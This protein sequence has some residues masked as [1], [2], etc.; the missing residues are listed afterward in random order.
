MKMNRNKE[1]VLDS[2]LIDLE[3]EKAFH[4]YQGL[5]MLDFRTGSGKSYDLVKNIARFIYHWRKLKPLEVVDG[6]GK[7]HFIKQIVVLIP[8][9]I[10]FLEHSKL[11]QQLIK[12]SKNEY[13]KE[14]AL[15]IAKESMY[16]MPSNLDCMINGLSGEKG[17]DEE[18]VQRI[19]ND[20]DKLFDAKEAKELIQS[21]H[22][23][24]DYAKC[25]ADKNLKTYEA[26]MAQAAN[27]A[28]QNIRMKMHLFIQNCKRAERDKERSDKD[29]KDASGKKEK[30]IDLI[31]SFYE[32]AN[33][34][35]YRVIVTSVDKCMYSVDP[36]ISSRYSIYDKEFLKDKLIILDE[37]DS[38]YVRMKEKI[39]E[40]INN[41]T[42]P[43]KEYVKV[44][45]LN[46]LATK[47]T[48]VV[49]KAIEMAFKGKNCSYSW[50]NLKKQGQKILKTYY[51]LYPY[52]TDEDSTQKGKM[53]AL[54][55]DG[56]MYTLSE[57]QGYI[58]AIKSA[59]RSQ[60][61]LRTGKSPDDELEMK[62]EDEKVNISGFFRDGDRFIYCFARFLNEVT[63]KYQGIMKR[64]EKEKAKKNKGKEWNSHLDS[65]GERNI[66]FQD[67]L[68]SLLNMFDIRGKE[69]EFYISYCL[70]LR[71]KPKRINKFDIDLSFYAL[72]Y[73]IKIIRD[74]AINQA[75]NSVIYSYLGSRTPESILLHMA[76]CTHVICLSATALN[77]SVNENFDMSYLED[78]LQQ[79]FYTVSPETKLALRKFYAHK[80][81]PYDTEECTV[82]VVSLPCNDETI[83]GDEK[84]ENLKAE[85]A[86]PAF[87]HPEI[88]NEL[89]AEVSQMV[90]EYRTEKK[91]DDNCNYISGRYMN[92]IHG[93]YDFIKDPTL[94]SM[95]VL[96]KAALKENNPRFDFELITS[97]IQ[98]ICMDLGCTEKIHIVT[99]VSANFKA[100]EEEVKG[101]WEN[102]EKAVF[103]ST[104]QT[105][106][107][108]SN[109]QYKIPSKSD[110]KKNLVVLLP[111]YSKGYGLDDKY[112]NKDVD[113]LYLGKYSYLLNSI[114][115]ESLGARTECF[116]K[117]IFEA[118]KLAY[119]G[120]ISFGQKQ[121]ILRNRYRKVIS[122][123][124]HKNKDP[125][126]RLL[127]GTEG[128]KNTVNK[129]IKQ[130]VGRMDRVN[131]KNRLTKIFIASEN[132]NLIDLNELEASVDDM[133]PAMK[134]IFE[135]A[136]IAQGGYD[137]M[138]QRR[139]EEEKVKLLGS[140]KNEES[141]RAIR[142]VLSFFSSQ[143]NAD[144][145]E[146]AIREYS[147]IRE[148]VMKYPTISKEDFEK[149]TLDEQRTVNRYYINTHRNDVISYAVSVNA[150]DEGKDWD[151]CKIQIDGFN[152]ASN[153]RQVAESHTILEMALKVD[154]VA[155]AFKKK[156]YC[157]KWKPGQY[158]LTPKGLDLYNGILGEE[159]EKVVLVKIISHVKV[160]DGSLSLPC[161]ED[162]APE[163]YE[164]FDFR[165]G[166]I[167]IDS[168]NWRFV[169]ENADEEA[170][171]SHVLKKKDECD[172][173]YKVN[174][175]AVILNLLP[176]ENGTYKIH[177][178]PGYYEIPCL[179]DRNGRVN[180]EAAKV[181]LDLFRKANY[182][183]RKN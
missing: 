132:L 119:G 142:R 81:M 75:E 7:T 69:Q 54:L 141:V 107:K 84:D 14:E 171:K 180:K 29:K 162:M 4:R 35:T 68:K 159:V 1:M 181:L 161:I 17:I 61:L 139:K 99:A 90:T 113:C 22:C 91:D 175:I 165:Y 144:D 32:T 5:T 147:R 24:R 36:I 85:A 136:K 93:L 55:N 9:K 27:T 172:A 176:L 126:S 30:C 16:I 110:I 80:E 103:F 137:P 109:L 44:L 153:G 39:V 130:S 10:N 164:R 52:K 134:K 123:G 79:N 131:M 64:N 96:E 66:S 74:N 49:S 117:V 15:R 12:L 19:C 116:H 62:P 23:I 179:I 76:Q 77:R 148:L 88:L 158:I 182:Y 51:V 168:K 8:N 28:E 6:E 38:A 152:M 118:E 92:L 25:K 82:D 121:S 150:K 111:E 20:V 57:K 105:T 156:G 87:K 149:M 11:A 143:V 154:G 115:G 163:V 112:N 2:D 78:R 146:D 13:S 42:F 58:H 138:E 71:N 127:K 122:Q 98:G 89:L 128:V 33:C 129:I 140:R 133:I 135:A 59:S 86:I 97:I 26:S 34:D 151:N 178:E 46:Y 40:R 67:D 170:F 31:K 83:S 73:D 102:G 183:A 157:T 125:F 43:F 21:F 106:G 160:L 101:Y 94:R 173:F 108:G 41:G 174:G 145:R 50:E 72:G 166:C 169:R 53:P 18:K 95:V 63:K 155:D 114:E 70:N 60:V 120:Q 3:M 124:R 100:K 65:T 56:T 167:Y 104:Y 177:G 37:S 47:P 45:I 48:A